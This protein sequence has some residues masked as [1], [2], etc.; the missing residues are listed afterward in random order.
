MES[1]SEQLKT[2]RLR[3]GWTQEQLAKAAGLTGGQIAHVERGARNLSGVSAARIA[4]ALGLDPAETRDFMKARENAA[5]DRVVPTPV[6]SHPLTAK[7]RVDLEA[8][9][10][11]GSDQ[12]YRLSVL[13]RL[14]ALEE[15][16]FYEEMLDD[17]VRA[18]AAD[19]DPHDLVTHVEDRVGE[20]VRG[21]EQHFAETYD[22]A[23]FLD[24]AAQLDE[25]GVLEGRTQAPDES[26]PDHGGDFQGP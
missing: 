8:A 19:G 11:W 25:D 24:H 17:M 9:E 1:I 22:P 2:Y 26:D 6:T 7:V 15:D 4:E 18:A 14:Y 23:D 3:R 12:T 5:A 20:Y 13:R 16:D 21:L 10:A